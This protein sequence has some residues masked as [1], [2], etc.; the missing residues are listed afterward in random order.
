M[1]GGST[2]IIKVQKLLVEYFGKGDN[3]LNKADNPDESV[4]KGACILAGMKQKAKDL[5]EFTFTD[6]ISH[7]LGVAVS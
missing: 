3:I 7:S 4:S 2:R 1:A 6:V 5:K